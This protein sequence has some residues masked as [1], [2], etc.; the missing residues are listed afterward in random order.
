MDFSLNDTGNKCVSIFLLKVVKNV[1][2]LNFVKRL[3]VEST[4]HVWDG[5][6]PKNNY[7]KCQWHFQFHL[8]MFNKP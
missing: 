6:G 3:D 8:E 7:F 2:K 5:V 4:R 1:F